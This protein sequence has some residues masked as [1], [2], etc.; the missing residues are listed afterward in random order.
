MAI[1]A[2]EADVE[3]LVIIPVMTFQA[4]ATPAPDAT[5]RARDLAELLGEGRRVSRRAG[6]D[7]SG[8]EG[9]EADVEMSA[10]SGELGVQAV[11]EAFFHDRIPVME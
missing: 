1:A 11:P 9:I 4:E 8:T 7:T 2:E 6:P 5:L 10:K 3:G